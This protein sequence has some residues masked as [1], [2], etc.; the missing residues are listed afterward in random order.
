MK[1]LAFTVLISGASL[2]SYADNGLYGDIFVGS[3]SYDFDVLLPEG[4]SF[5]GGKILEFDET[6]SYG[7]RVGY[8]LTNFVAIELGYSKFGEVGNN[9]TYN[10]DNTITQQLDDTLTVKYNLALTAVTLGV[11]GILPLT[12]NISLNAR[13]GMASWD[14][15][16]G[17]QN[18]FSPGKVQRI[19][20]D[21]QDLYYGVGMEYSFGNNFYA[22]LEYSITNFVLNEPALNDSSYKIEG[23]NSNTA[24][25]VGYRF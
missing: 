21:G 18:S 6:T 3:S 17:Y 7:L 4:E 25:S 12:N 13:L 8:Q 24:L 5:A 23:E 22:G 11:K 19:S 15:S 10:L 1:K 16:T 2:S 14:L 20:K 9:H